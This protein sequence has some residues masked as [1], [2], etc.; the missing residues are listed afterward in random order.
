MNDEVAQ[1]PR[2]QKKN[3]LLLIREE[4]T[5][6]II[7]GGNLDD[8]YEFRWFS[9]RSARWVTASVV[10]VVIMFGLALGLVGLWYA[11]I[12]ESGGGG[13]LYEYD[14]VR[15]ALTMSDGTVLSATFSLPRPK[16]DGERCDS[17]PPSS[18]S[19][20]YLPEFFRSHEKYQQ[21]RFFSNLLLISL[22]TL[23]QVCCTLRIF[24]ISQG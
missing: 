7:K 9:S 17:L 20:V 22:I 15:G 16:I 24:A 23:Y 4:E 1:T 5:T 8:P 14:I 18:P 12:G 2:Q 10:V 13:G 3:P 21:F 19:K 6:P 11:L